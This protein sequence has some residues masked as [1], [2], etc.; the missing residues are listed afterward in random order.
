MLRLKKQI[1]KQ[2]KILNSIQEYL[3]EVH[4]VNGSNHIMDKRARKRD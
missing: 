2:L 4:K 3:D 1:D